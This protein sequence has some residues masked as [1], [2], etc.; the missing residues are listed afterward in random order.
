MSLEFD[1]SG[2]K[3]AAEQLNAAADQIPFALSQ[4]LND[5]A[6]IVR[7][8]LIADVWPSHVKVRN[9][10]FIGAALTTKGRRATKRNLRVEIYDRLGRGSLALH[11]TGGAKR[12]RGAALAVPSKALQATRTSKG[13][14]AGMRPRALPNSFKKGDALYQRTGKGKTKGLKLAYVLKPSTAIKPTVPFHRDFDDAMRIEVR[15]AFGP[16]IQA[17]MKSRRGR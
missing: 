6:E 7:K 16:R 11:E 10:R 3:R 13:I 17:A 9:A 4:A 15:R 8:E 1:F 2:F 5:G 14:P 12:P